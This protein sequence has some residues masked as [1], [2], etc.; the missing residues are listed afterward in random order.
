MS[1]ESVHT[2]G[3]SRDDRLVVALGT[4]DERELMTYRSTAQGLELLWSRPCGRATQLLG[5]TGCDALYVLHPSARP[6]AGWLTRVTE[7]PID[8]AASAD[9]DTTIRPRLDAFEPDRC[10]GRQDDTRHAHDP[11]LTGPARN[12][13]SALIDEFVRAHPRDY[14]GLRRLWSRAFRENGSR[15]A[16]ASGLELQRLAQTHP[17]SAAVRLLAAQEHAGDGGWGEARRLLRNLGPK[18]VAAED[19][20]HLCHLQA[21]GCLLARD[22]VRARVWLEE[23]A[24]HA[25]SCD[26]QSIELAVAPLPPPEVAVARSAIDSELEPGARPTTS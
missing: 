25:G 7:Q 1:G 16:D 15:W 2:V 14:R 23:G 9:D 13:P 5:D 8:A 6:D 21:L 4:T 12:A 10:P 11:A 3:V 22:L 24:R 26:L 20:R 18:D 19:A 17:Q